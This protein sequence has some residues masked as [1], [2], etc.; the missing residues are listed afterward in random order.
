[1]KVSE[2]SVYTY[3]CE[4]ACMCTHSI[5]THIF[6][7]VSAF[8]CTL[9]RL[10]VCTDS[11]VYTEGSEERG[12][13][14]VCPTGVEEALSLPCALP[15]PPLRKHCHHSLKLTL[16]TPESL[17]HSLILPKKKKG[18]KKTAE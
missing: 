7:C 3:V 9:V 16:T 18:K 17:V 4:S 8:V 6:V 11:C 2:A 15:V 14:E 12:R 1:M 5:T 13:G 10:Y